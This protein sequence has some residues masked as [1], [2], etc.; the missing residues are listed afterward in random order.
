MASA[1]MDLGPAGAVAYPSQTLFPSPAHPSPAPGGAPKDDVCTV[2]AR[3]PVF[4]P[5]PSLG[6][7]LFPGLSAAP[8]AALCKGLGS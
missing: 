1:Q 3:L 2:P 8:F 5:R 4:P 6:S 7:L